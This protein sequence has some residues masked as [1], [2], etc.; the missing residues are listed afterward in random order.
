MSLKKPFAVAVAL[1]SWTGVAEAQVSRV[2]V[3]VNGN[4]LNTCSNLATPCRTFSGGIAQ[5]DANG[6]VIV[7]D[8]G[9]YAGGSITKSVKIDVAPGVIAFSGLPFLIDP[10]PSGSVVLRGLTLK[11]ATVGTGSAG[12]SH[13]SGTLFV[14]NS[15]IDGWN[16]GIEATAAAVKLFVYASTFRH[17]TLF[18]IT[19]AVAGLEFAI[20]E[21]VFENNAYGGIGIG[22]GKGRVSNTVMSGN[23]RGATIAGATTVVQFQRCEFSSNTFFG[24]WANNFAAV[25][26]A[27]STIARNGTGVANNGNSALIE[28]FGDNV[29][30][31]NTVN[32]S[33]TVT[34]VALQ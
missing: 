1:A 10:G 21:S 24:I 2:F 20:D 34:P 12:I 14:E 9:S 22:L 28:S 5:V 29:I 23:P 11:A 4:D 8:S 13:V 7:I 3:S 17:Q 16:N 19:T 27:E 15:V 26:I 6:E 32:L 33:G 18:G 31:G 30:L 25:R